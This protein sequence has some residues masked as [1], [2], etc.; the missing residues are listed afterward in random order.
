MKLNDHE[1]LAIAE[2]SFSIE[3]LGEK[4]TNIDALVIWQ[5]VR[6]NPSYQKD[7]TSILNQI[8]NGLDGEFATQMIC[9]EWCLSEPLDFNKPTLP[10]GF[11]FNRNLIKVFSNPSVL[12]LWADWNADKLPLLISVNPHGDKNLILKQISKALSELDVV[13]LDSKRLKG[14]S[15]NHVTDNFICFY[16]RVVLGL[17]PKAVKR[18]YQEIY[19][20]TNQLQN[21]QIIDKVKSFEQ[22]SSFA[23]WCFFVAP[24]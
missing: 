11:Y 1:L 13:Q 19:K 23:P 4:V 20:Q 21:K 15:I 7:Y 18:Q 10:E 12:K 5:Y 17:E 8:D 14:S 24:E 16:L 9:E 6:F 2:H 22:T 3:N